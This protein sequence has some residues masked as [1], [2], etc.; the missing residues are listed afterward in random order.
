M[1]VVHVW[2][3]F[4]LPLLT[5]IPFNQNTAAQLWYFIKCI[6]FGLS[7]WQIKSGY[8]LGVLGEFFHSLELFCFIKSGHQ[9]TLFRQSIPSL[10]Y[11]YANSS[12]WW[13]GLD[14]TTT[15]FVAAEKK[16]RWNVIS[17]SITTG[18]SILSENFL[19]RNAILLTLN[20]TVFPSQTQKAS[21][22]ITQMS[23]CR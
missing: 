16:I 5:G 11:Q 17:V 13:C 19:L 20:T 14:C 10:G 9:T 21:A 6:Y 2:V 3:F 4:I 7:A 22:V 15:L 18:L 8:P 23:I 1:V 12:K